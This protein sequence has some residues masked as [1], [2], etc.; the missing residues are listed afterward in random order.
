[1]VA[2]T[3]VR[4]NPRQMIFISAGFGRLEFGFGFGLDAMIVNRLERINECEMRCLCD[5]KTADIDNYLNT[6]DETFIYTPQK[7]DW[8]IWGIW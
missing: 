7:S 4:P 1:M 8:R 5:F 6:S 3:P 2:R